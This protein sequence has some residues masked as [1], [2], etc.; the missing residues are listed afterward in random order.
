[1]E[2]AVIGRICDVFAFDVVELSWLEDLV[3]SCRL[4]EKK[5]TPMANKA[6]IVNVTKRFMEYGW[7][8][9]LGILN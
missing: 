9:A 2:T 4:S 7:K 1:L 3:L 8:T 5:I 6:K